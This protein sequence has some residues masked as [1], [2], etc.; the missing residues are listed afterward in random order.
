MQQ[1][2]RDKQLQRRFE[3]ARR[4]YGEGRLKEAERLCRGM[5]KRHA[6][7]PDVLH[8]LALIMKDSGRAEAALG[9]LERALKQ[10]PH[11]PVCL[12]N[13]GNLL[14]EHYRFAEAIERYQAALKLDPEYD[15]AIYN[16]GLA[17]MAALK[18]DQALDCFL[19]LV[20][21]RPDDA[22]AWSQ[23]G[24]AYLD[25]G[26]DQEAIKASR[27]ALEL[28]PKSADAWNQLGLVHTDRGEFE[29]ALVCYRRALE[30]QPGHAKAA[31]N[32]ARIQRFK[33]GEEPDV[34]LVER[35]L[36]EARTTKGPR[37]DLHFALGK[38]S[39]DCGR[40]AEAF[41]HYQKA[42]AE[43]A[44][45]IKYDAD[46]AE[47]E[48]TRL[49]KIFDARFFHERGGFG[50]PSELPVFIVGMPRSGTTLIEQIVAAH[51]E[52]YGA[53][54]LMDI[55]ALAGGLR[56]RLNASA[57]YPECVKQIDAASSRKLAQEYLSGLRRR[58]P[59]ASRITDK[60]PGNYMLLG[61]IALLLPRARIIYC[62]RHPLDVA[63]SIYFTDFRAGHHY[64]YA[65]DHIAAHFRQF[66][67]LM[68]HWRRVIPAPM[69]EVRY[70]QVVAEPEAQTRLLLEFLGLDW[71][72][73]CLE[74][75]KVNRTV[76]TASAWQVRQPLY[77]RS[78]GRWRRY[79]PHLGVLEAALGPLVK[80]AGYD[81]G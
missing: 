80:Q 68:D 70:E 64:S 5:L 71:D 13:L 53:G 63:L 51:P 46:A 54:E 69:L 72:P 2:G 81:I 58:D 42:N 28:A 39:D 11:D 52:A 7:H 76:H 40:C 36:A 78:V 49:I 73:R 37:G 55:N 10:R 30:F 27:R 67:R 12:N 25:L 14:R 16:L 6:E 17:L 8:L 44:A 29:D 41:D 59:D 77:A 45:R 43:R 31:V 20:R 74:F 56:R 24:A 38:I 26:R 48:A 50:D 35:A 79:A 21:R 1:S 4:A 57:D 47:A 19:R 22:D 23:L 62:R 61:L 34:A 33:T 32:L 75:Q 3:S 15:S 66:T 65:L 9:L 18:P 60:L